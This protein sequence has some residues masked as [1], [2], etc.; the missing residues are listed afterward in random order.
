MTLQEINPYDL[1]KNTFDIIRKDFL[2]TAGTLEK[3]NT[4]TAGWGTLGI[5]W[6]KAVATVYVRPSRYTYDFM[7]DNETFSISTFGKDYRKMLNLCGTKSGRE[8]NKMELEGLT[9][10]ESDDTVYFKE[11]ELVFLCK[12]VY[13]HD[14]IPELIPA[15]SKKSHY[16]SGDFHRVYYG[17][18]LHC[19]TSD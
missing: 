2:L 15:D 16:G 6:S 14:L 4:M 12:K 11:A 5:L 10:L 17:E 13:S 7:E 8:I 9:P 1:V 18:I 3:Y 19:Y